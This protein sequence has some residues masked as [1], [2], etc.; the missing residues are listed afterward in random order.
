MVFSVDFYAEERKNVRKTVLLVTLFYLMMAAFGLIIDLSF[1]LFPIF[2][3]VFLAV[4]TIQFLVSIFSG[5]AMVLKSVG[6]R[7]YNP[8]DYEEKQ[9]K[10][11]VDELTIAAGLSEPPALYVI[12]NDEV[13]NAFATGFK[14]ED[15]VI[16]VTTGLLKS[17]DREETSGV[18]GHELSHIINRD[19]LIMTMIS[20]L[21][22]AVVIIQV[23]ALRALFSYLRFGGFARSRRRSK[24]GDNSTLAILAFL[25]AV[26]GLATLFSFVGK[27]SLFAVSRAREYFADAR[28]VELTRN[29]V[30]LAGALRKIALKSKKLKTASTA[31][32]HL[33]ITDPLK[34]KVNEKVTA[35]AS[36]FSTHPPIYMRIA[37]LENRPPE[38]V[39]EEL[40]IQ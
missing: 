19:I 22:G 24:K 10:N 36:L 3:T 30:G 33:F 31:T 13:I 20:A 40:R 16:C 37:V 34:R 6:A 18:I 12:E 25:A 35:F 11:I 2:S 14:R 21:I 8:A 17:L 28:A 5:K 7:P 26:A 32:A 9:L 4:A 23:F 15:A 39:K 29:P 27:L 1:G 38:E